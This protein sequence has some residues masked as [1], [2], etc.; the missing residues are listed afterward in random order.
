MV[1]FSPVRTI[2][3]KLKTYWSAPIPILQ[4]LYCQPFDILFLVL[5]ALAISKPEAK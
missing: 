2:R 1:L 4:L 5:R 3:I